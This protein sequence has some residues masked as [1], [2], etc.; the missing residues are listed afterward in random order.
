[1]LAYLSSEYLLQ[2]LHHS[3]L[4]FCDSNALGYQSTDP[5][6]LGGPLSLI[7]TDSVL[8]FRLLLISRTS[9][10]PNKQDYHDP[11]LHQSILMEHR[12]NPAADKERMSMSNRTALIAAILQLGKWKHACEVETVEDML[13][14]PGLIPYTSD[15]NEALSPSAGVLKSLLEAPD[16]A[17]GIIPA[18]TWLISTKSN[19]KSI[20]V[21]Y[22]GSLTVLERVCIANWFELHISQKRELRGSAGAL[23]NPSKA[24]LQFFQTHTPSTIEH[25]AGYHYLPGE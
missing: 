18:R 14:A 22:V 1:M 23:R 2:V 11:H 24:V 9:P 3:H 12:F 4:D 7:L 16:N 13:M 17:P 6:S 21:P 5:T 10:L 20:L 25:T 15:V 19:L 8:Q